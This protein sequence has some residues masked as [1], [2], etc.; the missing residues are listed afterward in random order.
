[1]TSALFLLFIP[2][3]QRLV[4]WRFR[5]L[6]LVL[7]TISP[8]ILCLVAFSSTL[9]ERVYFASF[10]RSLPFFIGLFLAA[11]CTASEYKFQRLLFMY[12]TYRDKQF[13]AK[14]RAV[15]KLSL[16]DARL[17]ASV[18]FA[19]LLLAPFLPLNLQ[20][21][22]LWQGL[23]YTLALAVFIF[24]ALHLEM[25]SC[26]LENKKL[27]WRTKYARQLIKLSV[28]SYHFYLWHYPIQAFI[29]KA[30]ANF[31]WSVWLFDLLALTIS[32]VI[33]YASYRVSAYL[34][35][36]LKSNVL[37]YLCI[38]LAFIMLCLPY[39]QLGQAKQAELDAIA[40]KITNYEK[41]T[42][43]TGNFSSKFPELSHAVQPSL[44][45]NK[46]QADKLPLTDNVLSE[47]DRQYLA[48][49]ESKMLTLM[50][51][52]SEL[53]FDLTKF[54]QLRLNKYT[55][56][57]DSIGIFLSFFI[58]YYLPN[59][60]LD[61]HSTRKFESAADV[62]KQAKNAEKLGDTVIALFGTN[63]NIKVEE[64]AEL[65]NLA[66]QDNKTLFL[67]SV[68]LPWADQE[69]ENNKLIRNFVKEHA[70]CYLIDWHK[71]A[72]NNPQYFEA[73]SIHPSASGCELYMHLICKALVEAS[74][75]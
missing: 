65:Y 22:Y 26:L 61:V 23:I 30:S 25:W 72:K 59:T 9:R 13:L 54:E 62:Y 71:Y 42:E 27:D 49:F 14:A 35:K 43:H 21:F 32:A 50:Q 70:D 63:G 48:Q 17:L 41:M 68:V 11:S 16:R 60:K 37:R 28:F 12:R 58:N 10:M 19:F 46:L 24:S 73:D 66:K 3:Y 51:N 29:A 2:L 47:E 18:S 52:K 45:I 53:S 7:A 38:C 8:I 39:A 40:N 74:T 15:C 20:S 64:I 1:M 36:Q 56:I 34:E 6:C 5:R 75:K 31:A 57:G 55:L 69:N 4:K 33:S 67:A 44:D